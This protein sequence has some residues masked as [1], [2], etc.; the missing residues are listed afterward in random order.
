[1]RVAYILV[2]SFGSVL[3]GYAVRRML[4]SRGRG[5]AAGRAS[6]RLIV[7]AMVFLLPLATINSLWGI[8]LGEGRLALLPLFGIL[9]LSLGG[10]A[11]LALVS[12]LGMNPHR[13]GAFFAVG[14][15]SNLSALAS[16]VAFMMFGDLGFVSIQLY[17]LLEQSFYYIV[18]FPLSQWVGT[19]GTGSF[20]FGFRNLGEKPVVLF[21]LGAVAAGFLLRLSPLAKPGFMAGLSSVLVPVITAFFGLSI[22]LTLK[23][24]R[25]KNYKRE[26][27]LAHGIKFLFIPAVLSLLGF[28]AGLPR[29]MGGVPF[30]S[31]VA[32][33]F[34]PVGFLAVV[35]PTIYGLDVDL[36]N[37][38]WLATTLTYAAILPLLFLVLA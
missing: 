31:L 6:S 23:V 25:M 36:A 18:G 27:A 12:A 16:F 19:R 1:M 33:S 37:S 7:F 15:F 5:G 30:K 35:P 11:A 10:A 38:A 32:A 26:I 17:V 8:S 4:E 34:S 2:V 29:V 21:P 13:G 22:G 24:S 9:A 14:M 20:R 3:A 28:L